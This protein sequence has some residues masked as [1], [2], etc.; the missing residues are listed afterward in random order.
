[1]S[2]GYHAPDT[3][4]AGTRCPVQPTGDRDFDKDVSLPGVH[5]MAFRAAMAAGYIIWEHPV[6]PGADR[7]HALWTDKAAKQADYALSRHGHAPR[8]ATP[9]RRAPRPAPS[10]QYG[11][12]PGE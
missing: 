9:P 10:P 4:K 1:M 3:I 12:T 2:G 8:P 11:L 6:R 5:R 7:S